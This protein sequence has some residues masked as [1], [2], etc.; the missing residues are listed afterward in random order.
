MAV[1]YLAVLIEG[2]AIATDPLVN[3]HHCMSSDAAIAKNA[4]DQ[5]ANFPISPDA[6]IWRDDSGTK[7]ATK[8]KFIWK[9][10]NKMQKRN[11]IGL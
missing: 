2:A 10:T 9:Q 6:S 1:I 8:Y 11:E 4:T 3:R 7:P 5:D